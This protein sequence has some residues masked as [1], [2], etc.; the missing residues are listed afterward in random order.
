MSIEEVDR[1]ARQ[2]DSVVVSCNAKLNLDYLLEILW[3]YLDLIRIYTK[4]RGQR[5]DF[6][7]G[8]ILRNGASI[9]AVCHSIHRTMVHSFK[10][11]LVW[12]SSVKFSPQRVGL[13]HAVHH[14]DVIQVVK[15]S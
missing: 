2:P 14:D 1:L 6:S 3:D 13:S 4:K 9:E 5:P 10:Y 12:G 11:A 7:D 15:K 8:I